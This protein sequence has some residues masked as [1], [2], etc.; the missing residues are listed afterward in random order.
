MEYTFYCRL[1]ID[2][3]KKEE[4]GFV[5]N[6]I[7]K[8]FNTHELKLL[9]EGIYYKITDY[10]EMCFDIKLYFESFSEAILELFRAISLISYDWNISSFYMDGNIE[11]IKDTKISNSP[12]IIDIIKWASFTFSSKEYN[13]KVFI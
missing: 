12:F 4:A 8:I 6:Q 10:Y 9:K 1:F 3:N 2:N 13:D 7:K 5:L 11:G